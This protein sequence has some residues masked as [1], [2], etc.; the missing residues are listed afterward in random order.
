MTTNE[1]VDEAL[2]DFEDEDETSESNIEDATDETGESTAEATTDEADTDD[3]A[4]ETDEADV[5]DIAD[6]TG[7]PDTEA[8]SDEAGE[9][10]VETTT[11]ETDIDDATEETDEA[12]ADD[13]AEETDEADA[14]DTAEET[15]E[16]DVDD[17]ADETSEPDTEARSDEAGESTAEITTD[18]TDTDDATEETD[19]ADADDTAEETDEVDADDI[20]DETSE[21]DTEARSDEAGESTAETTTDETDTDDATEETDEA[22]ADDT[23][24]ETDEVDADDIAD[25]TSEPDTEAR[26]DEAG[27]STVETTTDETDIDDATEE[28]DEADADDIAEETDEADADDTAEETD[29]VDVDDIADET[30]EPDTEA[31]S[32]EA[33]ESTAEI[34]TDETDTDDATEETDEADADDTAEETDEVDADDIAD[35]TSE[36]DT[37]ARS[38]EA[39]ESTAE[40][41]TDETDTDD[42]TEE[43]DEADAD[44]T[45]D[46]TSNAETDSQN[47]ETSASSI[48]GSDD[49]NNDGTASNS[50]AERDYTEKNAIFENV[51]YRQGQNDLGALGTCGPTSIANS[52]NRVTGTTEFTENKVL[53]NAMDNN[54]CHK[55]DNPYSCGGTTTRDVVNIIDNVKNPDDNIHT[56]VYEYDKALSVEDLANRLDDPGTVAMV[57]V[58]SAT[59][60]DQRGDVACSGLFQHT[61]SPSDHWITVDSPIRDEAGNLT[62]FNVIDS[63]GGVSEVSREKFEAMYMGDAGHTV[64]DPTAV[65]IS[66]NGESDNMYSSPEGLE[67]TSNYKGSAEVSD[68]NDPP[69]KSEIQVGVTNTE[70]DIN[71]DALSDEAKEINDKFRGDQFEARNSFETTFSDAERKDLVDKNADTTC[72]LNEN[73]DGSLDGSKY[74]GIDKSKLYEAR[75]KV[76]E[77]TPDTVMQKVIP[78]AQVENYLNGSRNTIGGCCSKAGDTAPFISCGEDAYKELRLD[79]NGNDHPE[80]NVREL[81][82]NADAYVIRF[83]TNTDSSKFGVP[84]SDPPCTCTGFLGG[85]NHLIPEYTYLKTDDKDFGFVPTDAAI[86]KIDSDG[87]EIMVGKWDGD[88]DRF[89]PVP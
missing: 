82:G 45:T 35:E 75:E 87:N 27:E 9:S 70:C 42:V 54:L 62:G 2:S 4:E 26:S 50:D 3:A 24:E 53:H 69:E 6:E 66:N 43:T 17:I 80:Y 55:S 72:A 19:E 47:G 12:D 83:T 79:Y 22:D 38:D 20:A 40:T 81:E 60:W 58:D 37:E 68:G 25:E 1:N 71:G 13:I 33:G 88:K 32:D 8:T 73:L 61:D 64:S 5:D 30:S 78:S 84:N 39:G 89:Y 16:V 29:E 49:G 21:P 36:P 18:E 48:D 56:E 57:G 23:A 15:D 10:T 31:T 63:G 51:S 7:E 11:D 46:G 65:I 52:L 85:E 34:T 14:D 67:R 59:L 41:T 86:Y 44:D 76:P 77:I 28:T 74:A